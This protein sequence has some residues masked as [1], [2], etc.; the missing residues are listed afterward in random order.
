MSYF[1]GSGGRLHGHSCWGRQ[2]INLSCLLAVE[3]LPAQR[4]WSRCPHGG[5]LQQA[6]PSPGPGKDMPIPSGQQLF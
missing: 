2:P 1:C 4:G 3:L 5:E 6:A